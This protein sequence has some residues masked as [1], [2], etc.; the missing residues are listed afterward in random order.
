M[1]F[2]K[3]LFSIFINDLLSTVQSGEYLFADDTNLYR[4]A[5]LVDAVTT[6]LNTTLAELITQ[7]NAEQC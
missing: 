1:T 4:N 7:I 2:H 5:E 3:V 6:R